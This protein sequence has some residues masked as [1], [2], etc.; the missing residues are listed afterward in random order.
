MD[1]L[2][3][4][5]TASRQGG[6]AGEL[7]VRT[8]LEQA[9]HMFN[10]QVDTLT[11]DSQFDGK[12][13]GA[14]DIIIVDPW[15]WAGRGWF[16]KPN[17]LDIDPKSIFVLDFFGHEDRRE[18]EGKLNVPYSQ[19][20]TAFGS[21]WKNTFLGYYVTALSVG[22]ADIV[23]NNQGVIWGKDQAYLTPHLPLIHTLLV[24]YVLFA[25]VKPMFQHP[26]MHWL[27]TLSSNA[28]TEL[29]ARSKFLLGLGDPLLGP[30]AIDAISAG[31]IFINPVYKEPK[32]LRY[33]SQHPYAEQ[34]LR[35]RVCSVDLADSMDVRRC[36]DYALG[37]NLKPFVP[38]DFSQEA[39]FARVKE[40][41]RID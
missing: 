13:L 38:P 36:I 1:S 2:E 3:S 26:N 37:L 29:L 16:P 5:E 27:G 19:F 20:L 34:N 11:S 32:L 30:S 6:A 10:V 8:S 17:L 33:T 7:R 28:W 31:C 4:Y 23:K 22:S 41:F 9:L 25:T 35:D 18:M 14:Y 40:I 12:T 24:D 39:Y 15:T 21:P